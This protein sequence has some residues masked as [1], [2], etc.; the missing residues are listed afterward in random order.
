MEDCDNVVSKLLMT[1]S[2][3]S[4]DVC[5]LIEDVLVLLAPTPPTQSL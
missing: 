3:K 5:N 4:R 1:C 2:G